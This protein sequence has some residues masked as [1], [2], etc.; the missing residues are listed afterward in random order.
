MNEIDRLQRLANRAHVSIH[1]VAEAEAF[2]TT[3]KKFRSGELRAQLRDD[4]AQ[5]D[6]GLGMAAI[7]SYARPFVASRSDGIAE[8]LLSP[9]KLGLFDERPDLAAEHDLVITMR[10]KV[11]AHSDWEHRFSL[12]SAIDSTLEHERYLVAFD[13]TLLLTNIHSFLDL[14]RYMRGKLVRL[15]ITLDTEIRALSSTTDES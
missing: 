3:Y 11:V 6:A 2:A 12:V 8:Q 4:I 7:V 13:S 10:N 5:L 9:E 1:D 15:L 14:T